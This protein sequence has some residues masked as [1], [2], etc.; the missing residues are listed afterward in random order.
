M[1]PIVRFYP[2]PQ[3]RRE[4]DGHP[5]TGRLA[6]LVERCVY[7]ANVGGSSPSAST[8]ISLKQFLSFFLEDFYNQFWLF[9]LLMEN[10]NSTTPP[11]ESSRA[12]S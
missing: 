5:K 6:Q 1:R 9:E 3:I 7:I 11:V 8:N 10:K 12:V 2:C 4:S